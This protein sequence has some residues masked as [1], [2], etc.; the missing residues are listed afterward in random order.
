MSEIL[1]FKFKPGHQSLD[2]EFIDPDTSFLYKARSRAEL[3]KLIV[4]YRI[5]NRLEPIENLQEVLDDYLCRKPESAGK[6]VPE[7]ALNRGFRAY[8]KGATLILKSLLYKSFATQE[9]A[10]R[11]SEICS[12]C[13]NNVFPDKTGFIKWSD[14]LAEKSTGGKKSKY[15]AKLGNCSVCTCCMKPKVFLGRDILEVSK[16]EYDKFPD[17]CW[18][19]QEVYPKNIK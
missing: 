18:Q 1:Y 13:P 9:E 12:T 19:K 14:A 2:W 17:F 4:Q 7:V 6:C 5:N 8:F 3:T 11:R 10:D 16:E 15:H